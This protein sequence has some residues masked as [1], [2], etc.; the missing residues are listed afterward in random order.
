MYYV[1]LIL[2]REVRSVKPFG[3][4]S[5]AR[6]SHSMYLQIDAVGG[7]ARLLA[8]TTRVVLS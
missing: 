7:D 2:Q 3:C 6:P 8:C 4:W 5:A 1:F